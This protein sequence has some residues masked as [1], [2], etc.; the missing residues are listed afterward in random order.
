MEKIKILTDSCLDLP[1]ELIKQ[2][3]IEVIPVLINFGDKSYI[4]REEINLEQ[5][6][7]KIQSEQILP[8]T[9]QI[10][11]VRFEEIFRKYLD[12]G[13]KVLT[14]LMSSN[15]SGTYNSA[16]IAKD[17]IESDDI[18]IVDTQVIT[19]AQGFFVLK[20]C[21]LRDKG[22]S[23]E[24]IKEEI[25]KMIPKMNASLCFESLENLVR[26][27]R[28]SKTAGVI[29]TALGLRVIIGFEDGMM[30]AKDKVRGNKKALKKIISDYESSNPDK[31]EP[32]ILIEIESPEM[33]GELK[34]YLEDNNIK[35]IETKPGCAVGIHSGTRVS[36]LFFMSK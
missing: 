21:E 1:E 12:E 20:A 36:G 5:M 6:Q 33:K 7:E 35:Y 25:I 31:N 13:Y 8:T 22:Y 30:T 19:S 11:P 3:N 27:G 9:A 16:C 34:K 14:I 28:I 15:M 32:V 10:T 17:M 4:D 26:G 2:N 24:A 23:A 29:G 18:V